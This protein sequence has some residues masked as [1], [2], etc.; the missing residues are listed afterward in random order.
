MAK[1]K[2]KIRFFTHLSVETYTESDMAIMQRK[3]KKLQS[4]FG[5][6]NVNIVKVRSEER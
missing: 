6:D 1:T 4:T 3:L 2:Y 5:R